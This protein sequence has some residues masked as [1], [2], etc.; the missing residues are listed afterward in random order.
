[1]KSELCPCKPDIFEQ[2]YEPVKDD[3][4]NEQLRADLQRVEG[5]AADMR[6]ALVFM[7]D[8]LERS[9]RR[10]VMTYV[11]VALEKAHAALDG[12]AGQR[13]QAVVEAAS[14]S[15][16]PFNTAPEDGSIIIAYRADAGAFLA[17]NVCTEDCEEGCW[18]TTDGEDLTGDLPTHWMPT[19]EPPGK[20]ATAGQ[21]VQAVVDAAKAWAND[22][23]VVKSMDSEFD[24]LTAVGVLDGGERGE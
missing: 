7:V 16:R 13:V 22:D 5:E 6:Q 21:R 17:H 1:M 2:T 10:G 8:A 4:N 12:A 23:G 19:P 11:P 14:M 3:Y 24:L 15:W 20:D 18:F 9:D